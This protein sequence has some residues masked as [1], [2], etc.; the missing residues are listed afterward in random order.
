M[1]KSV[2]NMSKV[3]RAI[4]HLITQTDDQIQGKKLGEGTYAVVFQ[5]HLRSDPNKL[6]AIKKF[7]IQ[8]SQQ[9][10]GLNVDTIREIKYLQE[11]SHPSIVALLDVFSSKDQN[12]NMVI[13]YFPHGNLEELIRDTT[14]NYGAADVKAWMGMLCRAIYYCHSNFILH[15]DIKPNN[16][17]IA[18]DGEVKLADFGL[19]RSFADP[20]HNMTP[21]VITLWYRPPELIFGAR[22]YGGAV[23]IWSI[24][25]VF[26]ELLI[27]RPYCAADIQDPEALGKGGGELAQL[28]KICE[29]VGT[30]SEDNWPGVTELPLWVDN[31]KKIPVRDKNFFTMMFPT[32]GSDG[33]DLLMGMLKLDPRKRLG[34]RQAL[35]HEWWQA[36]PRPTDKERLPKQGGGAI[37]MGQAEAK[38]PGKIVDESKFKGVAKKLDF[39]GR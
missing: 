17:L 37:V 27:R 22:H 25:M 7:K 12:I 24:G 33:V 29:A 11:I 26:A 10:E 18:A 34:A 13:E 16:L 14:V 2:T 1:K 8:E 4:T 9:T 28:D 20:Y 23:D 5:G 39:G 6:V 21:V 30:P 31:S 35:E 15:R 32:A 19:A 36:D 38:A 3:G